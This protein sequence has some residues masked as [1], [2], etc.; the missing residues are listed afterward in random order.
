MARSLDVI[1][2][3]LQN[4]S[5]GVADDEFGGVRNAV[6]YL[7]YIDDRE[8]LRRLMLN[9]REAIRALVKA[10]REMK[11]AAEHPEALFPSDPES[12]VEVTR[13]LVNV[14]FFSSL[15]SRGSHQYTL[16]A[17]STLQHQLES[18]PSLRRLSEA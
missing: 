13:L 11:A 16:E 15:G 8:Y 7:Q 6:R 2:E 14:Q 18:R 12:E 9:W 10:S 3:E 17:Q 4:S 5:L 1:Y